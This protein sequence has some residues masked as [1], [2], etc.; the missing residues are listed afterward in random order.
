MQSSLPRYTRLVRNVM[1]SLALAVLV[2]TGC[3]QGS[4]ESQTTGSGAP[5][6]PIAG[7]STAERPNDIETTRGETASGRSPAVIPKPPANAVA[8]TGDGKPAATAK[9]DN[10]PPLDPPATS[11]APPET[12]PTPSTKAD[13]PAEVTSGPFQ[14]VPPASLHPPT[15]V[16]KH[17]AC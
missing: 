12:L 17:R 3:Q 7:S 16:L 5:P 4:D 1:V 6:R 13:R 8:A 15:V 9:T 14:A 2:T 11:G 10:L